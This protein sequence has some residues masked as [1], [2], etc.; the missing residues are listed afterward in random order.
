ML[1]NGPVRI[2]QALLS[3]SDKSELAGFASC[4]S[5][6]FVHLISTGGTA[7]FL[8]SNGIR[9][10]EVSVY[11]GFPEILDGRVKT[12]HP[13]V[14]AGLL[15]IRDREAHQEEL[16]HHGIGTIDMVVVNLY[17]FRETAAKPGASFSD[18]IEQIDIGGPSMIRSAAKNHAY[19]AVVTDPAD[20]GW[21]RGELTARGGALSA[22][23]RFRLAMK[24]FALTAVYDDAI[25]R[26][27]AAQA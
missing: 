3:V 23:T 1:N 16:R 4:L 5:S 17:P 2:K 8:E 6:S 10:T 15:A 27:F 22:D 20:Y 14:H 18:V 25:A 26:Y 12:L 21:I 13:R 24:A 11:T 19:V 9:T 7:I